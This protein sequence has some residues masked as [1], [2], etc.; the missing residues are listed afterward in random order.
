MA[1]SHILK[2][3]VVIEDYNSNILI[4]KS[5]KPNPRIPQYP[6]GKTWLK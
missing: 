4:P 1:I 5:P 3:N 2:G 6:E